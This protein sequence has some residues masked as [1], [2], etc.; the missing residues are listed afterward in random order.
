MSLNIGT[1]SSAD[2]NDV[3]RDIQSQQ[4]FQ[5]PWQSSNEKKTDCTRLV[6]ISDTHGRHRRVSHLPP[7]DVLIHAGDFSLCGE[8]SIIEDLS[9]YFGSLS[10]SY[11]A[12]IAIAGNHDKVLHREYYLANRVEHTEEV[13]EAARAIRKNC[14]YLH[15]ASHTISTGLQVYGS[16]WTPEYRGWA[17]ML[18]RNVIAEK[19][20]QI[21]STTDI[22]IT[23]GPPLGRGDFVAK[24]GNVGCYELL[25]EIQERV[26]PRVSIFGH[27]HE[28]YGTTFDGTTLYVNASSVD[29]RYVPDRHAI[30]VDVP[31]DRSKPAMVVPP[32]ACNLKLP[33]LL[34]LCEIHGWSTLK[35]SLEDCN[36]DHIEGSL[37]T[38]FSYLAEDAFHVLSERLHLEQDS[39]AELLQA[40]RVAYA[41]SFPPC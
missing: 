23:H 38:N 29:V 24:S 35:Q 25:K 10:A 13:E 2:A 34:T 37:P 17:F 22:L 12:I 33:D 9:D 40:L 4:V 16:P 1:T 7:G 41:Q 30:V 28:G 21:P 39:Q 14:V 8:L 26:K 15:D 32:G 19:W 20:R 6:C 18:E 36:L 3:W 27:V 11:S 5:P 31:H